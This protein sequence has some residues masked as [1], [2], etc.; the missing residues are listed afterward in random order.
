MALSEF[1]YKRVEKLVGN[2]VERR[3]PPAHI[4]GELD[5]AFRIEGQSVV[6][7][8]IRPRWRG[9]PG[10]TLEHPCA[11]ATFVRTRG[12]WRILWMRAD[13]KWHAYPPLPEVRDVESFLRVVEEDAH[14]C[15]FG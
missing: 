9:A 3:R 14:H 7:F 13:L 15:F 11:K 4:R 8:E 10:E 5:F 2:F 12:V 1:E 6:L